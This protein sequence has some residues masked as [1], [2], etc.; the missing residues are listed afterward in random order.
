MA[1]SEKRAGSLIVVSN[2][3]PY[4]FRR[5]AR[6]V[7]A[8][9]TVGGLV[10]ALDPIL[11]RTNG[12]WVAWDDSFASGDALGQRVR[13]PLDRP[14][15]LYV[16]LPLSAPEVQAFYHGFSNRGLWPLCHYF[17]G[18]CEFDL[19]E[20]DRYRAVNTRFAEAAAAE[21]AP[22]DTIFVQDYQLALVP[23]M[24]RG[25][26]TLARI[27]LFW[28]IPFPPLDT[29]RALPWRDEIIEGMLGADLI[30]FHTRSYV[31]HF[32]ACAEQ[33]LGAKWDE[34]AG[35]LALGDRRIRLRACPLGVEFAEFDRIAR[36]PSTCEKARRIRAGLGT[37]IVVLGADRIDY[38][39]GIRE[40]LLGVDRFLER[41]P[42]FR[43]R[44]SF[45][46]IAAP[47]RTEVP[48]YRRLGRTIDETVGRVNG[49]YAEEAWSP[50]TYFCRAVP[51]ND[52]VA[53]YAAAD[54]AL[55][56]PLRD[57]LN[58]IA[59]EF[60]ASRPDGDGALILSE[61][62][63]AAEEMQEALLVNPYDVDDLADK[64][65]EA[66]Q[67]SEEDRRARMG[68]LRD[69]VKSRD[70]SW[71]QKEFLGDLLHGDRGE[72]GDRKGS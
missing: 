19:A 30:G 24:L 47:S 37:N 2:R 29:F 18:R 14:Q 23:G 5:H 48:E 61:F 15:Y 25:M 33:I 35:K 34:A 57:G 3:G 52:L 69:L 66:I 27:A 58:L 11:R 55:V 21:S 71:W 9:R 49:R 68:R 22:A 16:R 38:S 63:G 39:K 31:R 13:V 26:G 10:S 28:H 17:L 36:L 62:A 42:E 46:Q 56:T 59:K 32:A 6:G 20:Y 70:V 51:R 54:I 45:I 60:V 40:R 43:K 41:H 65:Y 64:I 53:Y 7:R 50:I 8:E 12:T 72:E 44:F 4:R 67:L 1:T